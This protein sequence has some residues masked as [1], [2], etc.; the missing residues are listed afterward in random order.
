MTTQTAVSM[1]KLEANE[2][3]I[4]LWK[5][6]NIQEKKKL[7]S[8]AVLLYTGKIMLNEVAEFKENGFTLRSRRFD[9]R[10]L[11]SH[12]IWGW[13]LRL[14]SLCFSY[15]ASSY[16]NI[17]SNICVLCYPTYE[18]YK[19]LHVSASRCHPQ[20]VIIKDIYISQHANLSSAPPYRND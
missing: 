2:T 20:E 13:N 6:E 17:S 10:D 3:K 12:A 7:W 5:K 18:I 8:M 16:I 19:L 4:N 15:H 9:F 14:S 1:E 11:L